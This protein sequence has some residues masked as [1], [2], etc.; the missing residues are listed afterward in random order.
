MIIDENY[1]QAL[2]KA[3]ELSDDFKKDL[4]ENNDPILKQMGMYA[5]S[6]KVLGYAFLHEVKLFNFI[7]TFAAKNLTLG[8]FNQRLNTDQLYVVLCMLDEDCLDSILGD[9]KAP[10]SVYNTLRKAIINRDNSLFEETINNGIT[11]TEP[12]T[13]MCNLLKLLN[14]I[15]HIENQL[16]E[17]AEDYSEEN[18]IVLENN[19]RARLFYK[20]DQVLDC[21]EFSNDGPLQKLGDNCFDL[22]RTA[23][24]EDNYDPK[25]FIVTIIK[26][27]NPD[28]DTSAIPWDD[29]NE[30]TYR[31]LLYGFTMLKKNV[32]L[33][34]Y[35]V[36]ALKDIILVPEYE[37]I[38]SQYVND[39]DAAK[40][41]E[42][43]MGCH[44]NPL[45]KCVPVLKELLESN[46][47][48]TGETSESQ[49][50]NHSAENIKSLEPGTIEVSAKVIEDTTE[51][52][53]LL[54]VITEIINK[55][56][57]TMF[58]EPYNKQKVVRFFEELLTSDVGMDFNIDQKRLQESLSS[59]ISEKNKREKSDYTYK[60]LNIMVFSRVIGYLMKNNV[61]VNKPMYISNALNNIGVKNKKY[62]DEAE[63]KQP[64]ETISKYIIKARGEKTE[65]RRSKMVEFILNNIRTE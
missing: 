48:N 49:P 54:E 34:R 31:S 57:D 2:K 55:F 13:P 15:Y 8:Y 61:F 64:A 29:I 46:T 40:K 16:I 24:D 26:T 7:K 38:W 20:L 17:E 37:Y 30:L 25:E 35:T 18:F 5:S 50:E 59:S 11:N 6:L 47:S 51:E 42:Q 27:F 32:S 36:D 60:G 22:T 14:D 4:A 43:S 44:I 3:A 53:N 9:I 12:I 56:D 58:E 62:A 19:W 1:K 41:I 23:V 63:A 10:D 21:E 45:Y 52:D 33:C 28:V 39:P 65:S